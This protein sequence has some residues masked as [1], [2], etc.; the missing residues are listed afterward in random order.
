MLCACEAVVISEQGVG[1]SHV[2]ELMKRNL[3]YFRDRVQHSGS[4]CKPSIE[5]HNLLSLSS[6]FQEILNPVL[7][8]R[9]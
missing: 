2:P 3:H 1:P 4:I 6:L 5:L 9:N 7:M 8:T